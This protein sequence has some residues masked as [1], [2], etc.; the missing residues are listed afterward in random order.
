MLAVQQDCR[1]TDSK[2]DHFIHHHVADIKAQEALV[3]D[4]CARGCTSTCTVCSW[5][6]AKWRSMPVMLARPAFDRLLVA[7]VC[8]GRAER[9]VEDRCWRLLVVQRVCISG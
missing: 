1:Y 9:T 3:V 2:S 6:T 4:G 7:P 8:C 5:E